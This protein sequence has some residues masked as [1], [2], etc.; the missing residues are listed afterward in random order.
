MLRRTDSNISR[1]KDL[2]C[3]GHHEGLFVADGRYRLKQRGKNNPKKKTAPTAPASGLSFPRSLRI[4]TRP[5]AD[6]YNREGRQEEIKTR[7]WCYLGWLVDRVDTTIYSLTLLVL[8][9]ALR[10]TGVSGKP[11]LFNVKTALGCVLILYRYNA[12]EC[13]KNP[14]LL[15][16]WPDRI[17]PGRCV[18]ASGVVGMK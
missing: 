3:T 4:S 9:V 12:S 2:H 5:F 6:S 1:S 10:R 16:I 14:G 18:V 11:G 17:R 7:D 13:R 8:R 15:T